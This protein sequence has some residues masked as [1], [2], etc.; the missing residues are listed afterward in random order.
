MQEANLPGSGP[1]Y[2]VLGDEG[3]GVVDDEVHPRGVEA[4]GSQVCGHQEGHLVEVWF[5]KSQYF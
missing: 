2:V 1:V 4:T 5:K 3:E